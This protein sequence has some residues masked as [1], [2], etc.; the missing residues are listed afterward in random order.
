MGNELPSCMNGGEFVERMLLSEERWIE[1]LVITLH[2]WIYNV[3]SFIRVFASSCAVLFN[4]VPSSL[5]DAS[6]FQ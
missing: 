2:S 1:Q 4:F 3:G 5:Y 6:G